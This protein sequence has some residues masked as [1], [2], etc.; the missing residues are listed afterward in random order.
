MPKLPSRAM[1]VLERTNLYNIEWD[2]NEHITAD[3]GASTTRKQPPQSMPRLSATQQAQHTSHQV[4]W[5]CSTSPVDHPVPCHLSAILHHLGAYLS[6]LHATSTS[7]V[8]RCGCCE[9]HP[10]YS[11]QDPES[12]NSGSCS[13]AL[14]ILSLTLSVDQS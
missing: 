11:T 2:T 8:H 12:A 13:V 9:C 5:T 6:R 14:C 3:C 7:T 10:S 4:H 1:H